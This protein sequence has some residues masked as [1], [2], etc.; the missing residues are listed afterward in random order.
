[1]HSHT[2]EIEG[3][4]ALKAGFRALQ[5][6]CEFCTANSMLARSHV[7]DIVCI[8]TKLRAV[9]GV[10]ARSTSKIEELVELDVERTS[11]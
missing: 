3:S 9:F 6:S 10:V 11:A 8:H 5:T 7:K 4:A 2:A 1:M